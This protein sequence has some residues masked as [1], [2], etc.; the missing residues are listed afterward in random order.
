MKTADKARGIFANGDQAL[1]LTFGQ[2]L[3]VRLGVNSVTHNNAD[4]GLE[5]QI[6]VSS[7]TRRTLAAC[8]SVN[9][10]SFMCIVTLD[11]DLPGTLVQTH[12]CF[13]KVHDDIIF[14]S[15]MKISC[16]LLCCTFGQQMSMNSA[17]IEWRQL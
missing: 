17:I 3:A 12:Q 5:N 16:T 14:Y 8:N 11:F 4:W 1:F 9:S 6:V 15:A 2:S 13:P 7:T 10:K